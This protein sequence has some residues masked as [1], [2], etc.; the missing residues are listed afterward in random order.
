MTYGFVHQFL[1][2]LVYLNQARSAS[3]GFLQ[4]L[5]SGKSVYACIWM[6]VCMCVCLCVCVHASVCTC[7]SACVYDLPPKLSITITSG[8]V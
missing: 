1:L 5:L 7:V 8:T 6:F 3:T 2:M 4:L